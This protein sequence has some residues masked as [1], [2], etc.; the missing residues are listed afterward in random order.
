M[1]ITPSLGVGYN[2]GATD[3][4]GNDGPWFGAEALF[5]FF[6]NLRKPFGVS[7]GLGYQKANMTMIVEKKYMLEDIS[8]GQ[9]VINPMAVASNYSSKLWGCMARGGLVFAIP[10]SAS[11]KGADMAEF[12]K[13]AVGLGGE[14]GVSLRR[15]SL[16]LHYYNYMAGMFDVDYSSAY[17]QIGLRLGI[18]F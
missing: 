15:F 11:C 9:L 6:P 16:T 10:M 14:F 17:V 3:D 2:V 5:E 4:F 7:V 12:V 13:T 1:E 18:M 8:V